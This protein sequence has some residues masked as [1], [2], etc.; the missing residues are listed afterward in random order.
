M[1]RQHVG[2]PPKPFWL[3][4]RFCSLRRPRCLQPL[5]MLL[6]PVRGTGAPP[7]VHIPAEWP[8]AHKRVGW[9]PPWALHRRL[10]K[11]AVVLFFHFLTCS[12]STVHLKATGVVNQVQHLSHKRRAKVDNE[13]GEGVWACQCDATAVWQRPSPDISI[14]KVSVKAREARQGDESRLQACKR[15]DEDNA[16]N[17][18]NK[19]TPQ[20]QSYTWIL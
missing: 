16:P 15:T 8:A 18:W 11:R 2:C 13:W 4:C 14:W 6:C 19:K 3:H 12:L 10:R 17:H 5:L 7:A 20:R 9:R 1:T